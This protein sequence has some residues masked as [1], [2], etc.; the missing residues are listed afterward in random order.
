M[1]R[2]IKL[3]MRWEGLVTSMGKGRKVYR[4]LVRKLEGKKHLEARG[5]DR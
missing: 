3:R 1:I 4:V 2:Q 5:V